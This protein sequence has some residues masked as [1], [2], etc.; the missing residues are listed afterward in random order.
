MTEGYA[1]KGPRQRPEPVKRTK[2]KAGFVEYVLFALLGVLVIVGGLALYQ[3]FSPRNDVPN[4]LVAGYKED[5]VNILLIGI[6]G[7]RK[8]NVGN[9]LADAIMLVSL[10]PSQ[11]RA[12][13]ISIP[14][15]LY[16]RIGRF[17]V[18]RL[19]AAH[20]LGYKM[21]YR[22]GGPGLLME[23]VSK[24]TGQPIHAY[25]RIDFKAFSKVIDDLGG[26][27]VFVYRPFH[28]YLFNDTFQRGWQH[29]NGDRAL[30]YA[31]YRYVLGA[32]GNNF[33]R[34]LRQQQV[35]SAVKKKLQD[36]SM[37]Q[38][39]RLIGSAM[40][41]SKYT[42]TNISTGDMV[43]LYR[44]FHDMPQGSIRHVSLAPLTEVFMVTKLADAGEAVRP[45]GE[46]YIR[47]QQTARDVFNNT[48]PVVTPDQIQLSDTDNPTPSEVPGDDWLLEQRRKA[49]REKQK[50]T[51]PPA[52]VPQSAPAPTPAAQSPSGSATMGH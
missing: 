18:H 29:M 21:G 35:L 9:D 27:D 12:A 41:V 36:V 48:A 38:A 46:N 19:N 5:R 10:R 23:T 37:A 50:Q 16:L 26:V 44:K 32:E 17:G 49:E 47:I 4:S 11:K 1:T 30:R 22:G 15:D 3:Q 28:D 42:A 13:I 7:E 52:H 39:L 14:R 8:K 51:A 25:A 43:E 2:K 45:P 31:R 33:A 20:D 6:A 24:V 34:E 40:T